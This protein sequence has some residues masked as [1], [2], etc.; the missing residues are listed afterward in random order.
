MSPM[1]LGIKWRNEVYVDAMLPFGLR[2]M[3]KI[4]TAVADMLHWLITLHSVKQVTH[5]LDDSAG[6]GLPDSKFCANKLVF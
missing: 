3:L 2:S 5:C 6:M 4:F 1:E